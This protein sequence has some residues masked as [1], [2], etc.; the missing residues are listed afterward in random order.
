[1]CIIPDLNYKK[2]NLIT[3]MK[4]KSKVFQTNGRLFVKFIK[5]NKS[6]SKNIKTK[7]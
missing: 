4:I 3:K 5:V 7:K 2:K 1:M 6:K